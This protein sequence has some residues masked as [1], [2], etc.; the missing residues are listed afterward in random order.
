MARPRQKRETTSATSTRTREAS[1]HKRAA[2]RGFTL[3]KEGDVWYAVIGETRFGPLRT[4][5]DIEEFLP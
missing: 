2:S 4:F 3:V 1:L 5:A